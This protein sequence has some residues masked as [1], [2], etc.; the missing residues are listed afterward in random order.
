[1]VNEYRHVLEALLCVA[2]SHQP[3]VKLPRISEQVSLKS[4]SKER[5]FFASMSAR[6]RAS[7]GFLNLAAP[8]L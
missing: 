2:A 6:L 5:A 8:V 4:T 1:M 3:F 7:C